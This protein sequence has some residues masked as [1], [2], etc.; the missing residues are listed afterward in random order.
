MCIDLD[1]SKDNRLKV[2]KLLSRNFV[3]IL[4][5]VSLRY[6]NHNVSFDEVCVRFNKDFS[7]HNDCKSEFM[8]TISSIKS[9]EPRISFINNFLIL[10]LKLFI[11]KKHGRNVEANSFSL[12]NLAQWTVPMNYDNPNNILQ[13]IT[14]PCNANCV[15]CFQ[16]GNPDI[17]VERQ[18]KF[19]SI[20]EIYTRINYYSIEKKQSLFNQSW[21][22][23]DEALTHP[24]IKE[25]LLALREKSNST[26]SLMTNGN[27]LTEEMV[28]FL[29]S[30]K[31]IYIGISLNSSNV[32]IRKILMRDENSSVAIR[33]LS[34]MSKYQ[35]N[36]YVTI[37]WW[38]TLPLSDIL[39]TIQ[40]SEKHNAAYVRIFLPGYTDY[41]K[42][43]DDAMDSHW[44]YVAGA[45]PLLRKK[46]NIPIDILPALYEEY[47][48]NDFRMI[49][50]IT[51]IVKGSP[52]SLAGLNVGDV[53]VEINGKTFE[54]RYRYYKELYNL[55]SLT[56]I[57]VKVRRGLEKFSVVLTNSEM[58]NKYPFVNSRGFPFGIQMPF[59]LNFEP[60]DQYVKDHT[61]HN[62]NGKILIIASKITKP[63]IEYHLKEVKFTMGRIYVGYPQNKFLGGNIIAGGMFSVDDYIDY[64]GRWICKY[65]RP[66]HICILSASFGSRSSNGWL[67]DMIG[68]NYR[69]IERFF[70]I[71]IDLIDSDDYVAF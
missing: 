6:D 47:H 37:A 12:K 7:I 21:I 18:K 49:P 54:S 40:F 57:K 4:D 66:D 13:Y 60:L 53:I 19:A 10:F 42:F 11:L 45:L 25:L 55:M 62:R 67:R 30:L 71:Q 32:R 44:R 39:K 26:L 23:I 61:K 48:M 43:S 15:F 69:N 31:P 8:E 41:Y 50:I 34:L 24:C 22:N 29:N 28:I 65:G 9:K 63:F 20:D 46:N 64:I 16:K 56:R 33:S 2:Y 14:Y 38:P 27:M 70:E 52:A 17:L 59:S 5:L 3:G 35:I 1:I 68:N 36:Y 58:L 51:G